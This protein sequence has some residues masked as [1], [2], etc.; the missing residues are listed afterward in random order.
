MNRE[1]YLA[2]HQA[3]CQ[4]ALELSKRKNHDYSGGQDGTNPF[5]NFQFVEFLGMNVTTEQGF[6]VRLADKFKRLGG[7]M[8]T[9]SFQVADETFKDTC[10]DIINYVALLSAYVESKEECHGYCK[11]NSTTTEDG[12][13]C[14][15]ILVGSSCDLQ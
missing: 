9:G 4:E 2:H 15:K 14:R 8:G 13:H 1:Q 3:L 6:M 5:L 7:F 10:L 12:Q 11:E